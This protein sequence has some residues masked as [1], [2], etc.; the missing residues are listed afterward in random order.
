[1]MCADLGSRYFQHR[2]QSGVKYMSTGNQR[3]IYPVRAIVT[4]WVDGPHTRTGRV[5]RKLNITRNRTG[6]GYM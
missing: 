5:T 3:A 2:V 4:A 6:K 1:M